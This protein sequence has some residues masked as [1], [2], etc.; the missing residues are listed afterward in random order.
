MSVHSG[1]LG[2]SGKLPR[3]ADHVLVAVNPQA[4]S[5]SRSRRS[6]ITELAGRLPQDGFKT[7]IIADLDRLADRACALRE[8]GRL[9][10][11]VGAGGDGTLHVLLNRIEPGIPLAMLPLGTEN[12]LA[13]YLRQE[14]GVEPLARMIVAGKTMTLDAGRANGRL[15]FLMAS[16]G[17]DA[18]VARRLH[19][20]RRGNIRH[21]HYVAPILAAIRH[22]DFPR[23]RLTLESPAGRQ[24]IEACWCFAFNLPQYGFG[25]PFALEAD[26]SDGLLDVCTFRHGSLLQGLRY[27]AHLYLRRH[28]GLP[29]CTKMKATSIRVEADR[30][31]PYQL[32]GDPIGSLPLELEIVP[33]RL[34]LLAPS[35]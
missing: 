4:G 12:L 13:K 11:V 6:Q 27:T 29:D 33:Q 5:G 10:T 21:W 31:V 20:S 35:S 3:E 15:F 18:D 32:D 16:A 25:L 30:P 24:E 34:T 19:E 14:R 7:E 9:R 28:G 17:F 1:N 23:L 26:G 8:S 2:H 22:Y